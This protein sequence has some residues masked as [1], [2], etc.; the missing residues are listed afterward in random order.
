MKRF[1]AFIFAG[2]L[3]A[4]AHGTFAQGMSGASPMPSGHMAMPSCPAPDSVVGVNM[5]T[6]MYMTKDQMHAKMQGMT[7][8]QMH[9][10]MQ[11][12]NVQ[13]MCKSKA[14]KMGAKPM[15]SSM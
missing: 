1:A 7:Q 4:S 9:A 5:T 11:K 8:D 13:M 12:N 15:T 2:A 3:L 10:M 6:K 14:D